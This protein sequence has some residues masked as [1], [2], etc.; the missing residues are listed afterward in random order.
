MLLQDADKKI[1][2]DLEKFLSFEG[3]T[4]PYIQYTHARCCSIL[5]Q[6][7]DTSNNKTDVYHY[8]PEERRLVLLLSCFEEIIQKSAHELKP[9]LIARYTLTI[10]Q[11]FNQF[12]QHHKVL[13]EDQ[14]IKQIRLQIVDNT[15]QVLESANT[16][17]GIDSPKKM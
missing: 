3:E 2:F 16:L 5:E 10:C 7:K 15:R 1:I 11:L 14:T 9:N 6:N 12:Y 8:S 13:V 4:G 17:L